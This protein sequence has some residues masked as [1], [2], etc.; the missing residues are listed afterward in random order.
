MFSRP[1]TAIALILAALGS[2]AQAEDTDSTVEAAGAILT[3]MFEAA[4]TGQNEL[5]FLE[6]NDEGTAL[7]EHGDEG[8]LSSPTYLDPMTGLTGD[9]RQLITNAANILINT[10]TVID[11]TDQVFSG[12]Q[13][14]SNLVAGGIGT[15]Q[16]DDLIQMGEN[17]A[18]VVIADRVDSVMQQFGPGAEQIVL[19][20]TQ[21]GLNR[22]MIEQTG[23]NTANIV[24]A[25]I[26][27]G[28]G[29]QVFPDGSIQSIEN[30]V[31]LAGLG[32]DPVDYYGAGDMPEPYAGL[33]SQMMRA[34]WMDEPFGAGEINQTGV[35]LG[36]ILISEEVRDVSRIFNG[37]QAILNMV[38]VDDDTALPNH[39]T[40]SGINIANFV[41]AVEVSG[42]TQVSDGIQRVQN[43]VL[44]SSLQSLTE[45]LPS[46]T[47]VSENFV[48][49]LHIREAEDSSSYGLLGIQ[50][51]QS[52]TVPQNSEMGN[53]RQVQVGNAVAVER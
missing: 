19:N 39:V 1:A 4:Q 44:D 10:S 34:E 23:R 32:F 51:S 30:T 43:H 14:A 53:G 18:N 12:Q 7:R 25:E 6:L 5:N 45:Q 33:A 9:N 26:S 48:N 42:L 46:Y 21:I 13:S 20:D 27:I 16:N 36:N 41:S 35:N 8:Y 29:S 15:M 50:A 11:R 37:E 40:Q 22:G 28:S 2:A 38:Y 24:V 3:Q 49:V 52:N 47:H 31:R 17:L